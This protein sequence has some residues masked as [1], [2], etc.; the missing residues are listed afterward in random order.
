MALRL[1]L[2]VVLC[3]GVAFAMLPACDGGSDPDGGG[4]DPGSGGSSSGGAASGGAASGGAASGGAASGGSGTGGG[5]ADVCAPF[6]T[7][8]GGEAKGYWIRKNPGAADGTT[9]PATAD[10][11][12][13]EV[14]I[15]TT[16]GANETASS[17]HYSGTGFTNT[18][19]AAPGG[20]NIANDLAADDCKDASVYDGVSLWAYGTVDEDP[21]DWE[22]AENQIVVIVGDSE[23]NEMTYRAGITGEWGNV[24]LAFSDTAGWNN[25]EA[26]D[27]TDVKYLKVMVAGAAFDLH[28][29]ELGWYKGE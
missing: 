1:N 6:A 12:G 27:L 3:A 16:E 15:D 21:S 26:V 25:E 8:E 19:D 10:L 4:G 23:F 5:A 7:F 29:D 13:V 18:A 22:V 14:V 11:S 24:K 17:V 20:I 2:G 9:V 28:I